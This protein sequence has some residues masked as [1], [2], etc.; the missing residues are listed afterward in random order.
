MK[1]KI[2]TIVAA[3]IALSCHAK[4]STLI[5]YDVGIIT[6]SSSAVNGSIFFISSGIDGNFNSGTFSSGATTLINANDTLLFATAVSNGIASG[7]WV[8]NFN[9]PVATGQKITALFVSGLGDSDVSYSTGEFLG[10]K[11]I[12]LTGGTSYAFGTYRSDV[13]ETFGGSDTAGIAWLTPANGLA[14]VNLNAYSNTGS[15]TGASVAAN[16]ATSS[17]FA[18]IPEPSSA[19]LLAIGVAG[20]VAL[21]VRRKS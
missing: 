7:S 21:R 18:L 9:S 3:L 12:G 14:L 6:S 16:L 2:V 11:S 19:S 15:Y 1:N 8:E 20:L 17:S 5:G 4:A 13:A 10:G